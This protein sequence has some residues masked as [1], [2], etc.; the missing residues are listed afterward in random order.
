MIY[1]VEACASA[2]SRQQESSMLH[3]EQ[4]MMVQSPAYELG[5]NR[6]VHKGKDMQVRN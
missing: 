6:H 1:K 4:D 3:S 5:G 2:R